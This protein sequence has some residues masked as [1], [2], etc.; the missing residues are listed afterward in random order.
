MV[1]IDLFCG[2]GGMTL[3]AKLSG[4]NVMY[5]VENDKYAAETYQFN[6]EDIILLQ[7]DIRLI[8]HIPITRE[9][10]LVVFGGPPCQGF[11]TSNQ[12]TRTKQNPNNWLFLEFIRI[13]KSFFPLPEWVVFENVKGFSETEEGIFLNAVFAQLE[14]LGYT[15][16]YGILNSVDFG[17]PQK[18]S[19]LFAIGSIKGNRITFPKTTVSS[20]VTVKQAINDLPRLRN[21]ATDFVLPYKITPPSNYVLELRGQESL[22]YNNNVTMNSANIL[23]RYKHIP[24]GGNWQNIPNS[25]MKNYTDKNRCH[26]GIYHRLREDQPSV[27]IGNYRKNMLIHPWEDRGLSVREAARLQSFPDWYIFKGS[28]GF[29]QQ[30]VG[31]AV[32]PKLAKVVFDSIIKSNI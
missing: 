26:T 16:S 11:S 20:H 24:Q 1:G 14:Q 29:Q 22:C 12:K 13:V 4:V 7:N 9:Q 17:V 19:R 25:L 31:N 21:G 6:N 8:S 32:P 10:E 15:V 23:K 5:A 18:R 2:A 30:Q 28:I 3:G 27:V